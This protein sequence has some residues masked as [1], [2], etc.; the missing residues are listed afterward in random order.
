MRMKEGCIDC[1]VKPRGKSYSPRDKVTEK[2]RIELNSSRNHRRLY[3]KGRGITSRLYYI[4]TSRA[5]TTTAKSASFYTV[6]INRI[7]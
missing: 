4:Q 1:V 5:A 3:N 6:G 7:L 2:I